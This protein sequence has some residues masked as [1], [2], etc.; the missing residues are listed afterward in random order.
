MKQRQKWS[1]FLGP[2]VVLGSEI[3]ALLSFSPELLV[4]VAT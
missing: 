2:L 4:A 1:V 3:P